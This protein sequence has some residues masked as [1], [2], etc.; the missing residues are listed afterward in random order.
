M[1]IMERLETVAF[2]TLSMSPTSSAPSA[3]P[4]RL[5]I[6]PMITTTSE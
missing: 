1:L 2:V 3:A 6:P 5:P 4:P